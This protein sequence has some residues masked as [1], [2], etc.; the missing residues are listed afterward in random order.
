M[1]YIS[2]I[3][4]LVS[5]IIVNDLVTRDTEAYKALTALKNHLET[6][7][8]VQKYMPYK[9]PGPVIQNLEQGITHQNTEILNLKKLLDQKNIKLEELRTHLDQAKTQLEEKINSRDQCYKY[10]QEYKSKYETL[11]QKHQDLK[12]K[13]QDLNDEN[14]HHIDIIDQNHQAIE[15]YQNLKEELKQKDSYIENLKKQT[16]DAQCDLDT[17][18]N[19][20]GPDFEHQ[21][22]KLEEETKILRSL[23]NEEQLTQYTEQTKCL[24]DPYHKTLYDQ[25]QDKVG[26]LLRLLTQEQEEEYQEYLRTQLP[27]DQPQHRSPK[28]NRKRRTH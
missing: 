18:I 5:G 7:E 28:P 22:N 14:A 19:Y 11:E 12:K 15:N 25:E 13:F 10:W 6:L 27:D 21:I 2:H 8:E 26:F 23:L 3:K 9:D 24:S 20:K 1:K 16:S 17:W 4:D